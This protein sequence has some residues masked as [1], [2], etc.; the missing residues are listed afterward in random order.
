MCARL[1]VAA[2]CRNTKRAWPLPPLSSSAGNAASAAAGA[3]P[4]SAYDFSALQYGADVPLSKYRG[5]V[6]MFV[7]IASE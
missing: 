7:N 3:A 4:L 5:Q 6:V 1:L 2:S